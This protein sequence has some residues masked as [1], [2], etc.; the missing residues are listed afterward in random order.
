M[1]AEDAETT[2][3]FLQEAPKVNSSIRLVMV[4][5]FALVAL[6][7]LVWLFLSVWASLH[8]GDVGQMGLLPIPPSVWVADFTLLGIATAAKLWQYGKEPANAL[9]TT[10]G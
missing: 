5:S 8:T 2:S 6:Q 1:N 3:G 10:S 9:Q 7:W 4:G